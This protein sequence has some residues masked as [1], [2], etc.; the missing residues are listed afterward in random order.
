MEKRLKVARETHGDLECSM[1]GTVLPEG[2]CHSDVFEST[3]ETLTV[4]SHKHGSL[5]EP[6]LKFYWQ[7]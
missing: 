6:R 4:V 5:T 1:T 3:I 2:D 7:M